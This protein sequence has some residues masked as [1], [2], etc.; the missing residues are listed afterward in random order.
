MNISNL[1]SVTVRPSGE[2]WLLSVFL[3]V[4][5]AVYIHELRNVALTVWGRPKQRFEKRDYA[6]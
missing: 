1:K 5:E 4:S 2:V 3:G 6:L